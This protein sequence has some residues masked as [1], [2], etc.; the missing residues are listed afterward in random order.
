[1][2]RWAPDGPALNRRVV[3][4]KWRG[5]IEL[6]DHRQLQHHFIQEHRSNLFAAALGNR[7]VE[8]VAAHWARSLG[9]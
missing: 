7:A 6:R 4:M 8:L 2:Q 5:R 9:G 1:M 3:N